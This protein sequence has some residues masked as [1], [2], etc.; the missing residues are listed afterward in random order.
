[1]FPC[2]RSLPRTNR[3]FS[4]STRRITNL[5]SGLFFLIVYFYLLLFFSPV[6]LSNGKCS[7]MFISCGGYQLSKVRLTMFCIGVVANIFSGGNGE[8][9]KPY[10]A[11]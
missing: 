9:N 7:L 4:P 8:I 3:R 1:M 5:D 11:S 6:V 10:V 2:S